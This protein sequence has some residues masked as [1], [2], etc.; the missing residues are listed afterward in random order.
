MTPCPNGEEDKG[1]ENMKVKIY[2]ILGF[3]LAIL[4]GLVG[5][6]I[7]LCQPYK[8]QRFLANPSSELFPAVYGGLT[9]FALNPFLWIGLLLLWRADR[10]ENKEKKSKWGKVIKVYAIFATIMIVI[11]MLLRFMRKR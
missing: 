9:S 2:R 1:E 6:L 10:N 8:Y 3:I 5:Y 7:N 4:F 11:R